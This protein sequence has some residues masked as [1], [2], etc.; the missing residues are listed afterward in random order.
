MLPFGGSTL[1]LEADTPALWHGFRCGEVGNTSLCLVA[2]RHFSRVVA[3]LPG[4]EV[5][6][7]AF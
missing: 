1:F 4:G 3:V 5:K 7:V 6:A 2:V